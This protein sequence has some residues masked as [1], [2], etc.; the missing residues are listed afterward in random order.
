[1]AKRAERQRRNSTRDAID[2]EGRASNGSNLRFL[3]HFMRNQRQFTISLPHS[4]YLLCQSSKC[5]LFSRLVKLISGAKGEG[6]RFV[7]SICSRLGMTEYASTMLYVLRDE[8]VAYL[9]FCAIM[10]RVRANFS[11]DGVAIA[12]KF[13]HL[14]V[15]LQ[16]IDPVYWSFLEACD[17]GQ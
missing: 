3:R 11:T 13:H 10:R 5:Q 8:A 7:L 16:A 9:G 2:H 6:Q 1:M 14:K 12:T 15:L 17:A 4:H